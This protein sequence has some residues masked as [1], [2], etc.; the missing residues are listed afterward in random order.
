M[1]EVLVLSRATA[2]SPVAC[3]PFAS[4]HDAFAFGD[5]L[6][7]RGYWLYIIIHRKTLRI[8]RS[9]REPPLPQP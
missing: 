6:E 7:K 5:R 4:L 9:F 3:E 2:G 1:D 8:I